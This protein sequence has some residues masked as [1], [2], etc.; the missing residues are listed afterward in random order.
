M[1]E[2]KVVKKRRKAVRELVKCPLCDYTCHGTQALGRHTRF[3]HPET[4][5]RDPKVLINAKSLRAL[6]DILDCGLDDKRL[7]KITGKLSDAAKEQDLKIHLT[8]IAVAQAKALRAVLLEG[9]LDN[10]T[11]ALV[12]KLT[13]AVLDNM[14]PDRLL[15]LLEKLNKSVTVDTDYLKGLL[16]IKDS[17]SRRFFVRAVEMLQASSHSARILD[18]TCSLVRVL[19]AE[20][21]GMTPEDIQE[22]RGM[23]SDLAKREKLDSSD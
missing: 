1:S 9:F 22:F 14:Q 2:V 19:E 11:T 7:G 4:L 8:L 18:D 20:T 12:K 21:Q 13:P 3:T 5:K 16:S 6:L 17:G 15:S 23:I 10:I